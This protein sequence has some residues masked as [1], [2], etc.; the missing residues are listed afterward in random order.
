MYLK[1]K[2]K[3]SLVDTI[4]PVFNSLSYLYI[5]GYNIINTY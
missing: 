3:N 4:V 5:T 1:F 2:T